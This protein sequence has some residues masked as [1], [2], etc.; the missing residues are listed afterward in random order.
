[1]GILKSAMIWWPWLHFHGQKPAYKHLIFILKNQMFFE[2]MDGYSSYLHGYMF[3]T[4]LKYVNS[5]WPWPLYLGHSLVCRTSLEPLT[6]FFSKLA[7]IYLWDYDLMIMT[8]LSRWKA[9]IR[10]HIFPKNEIFMD[11]YQTCMIHDF[12]KFKTCLVFWSPCL[13]FKFKIIAL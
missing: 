11:I 10:I 8:P 9:N 13:F 3:V 2:A 6:E 12:G 5:G 7:C 1:M 4:S